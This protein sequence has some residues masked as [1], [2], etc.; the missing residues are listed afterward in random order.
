M[1]EWQEKLDF[2]FSRSNLL[3]IKDKH[4]TS[5]AAMTDD[6]C[7]LVLLDTE[8]NVGAVVTVEAGVA[9]VATGEYELRVDERPRMLV[10]GQHAAEAQKDEISRAVMDA[11][12][13]AMTMDVTSASFTLHSS[14]QLIAKWS[15]DKIGVF[16]GELRNAEGQVRVAVL[17]EPMKVEIMLHDLDNRLRMALVLSNAPRLVMYDEN[18]KTRIQVEAVFGGVLK[19]FGQDGQLL[20]QSR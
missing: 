14:H 9:T 16:K 17:C 2:D 1:V 15:T 20:W 13:E 10:L 6:V 12:R 18:Q 19:L 7:R 3:L 8:C 4:G 11:L 5:L